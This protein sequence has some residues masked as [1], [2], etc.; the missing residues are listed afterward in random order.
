MNDPD[1]ELGETTAASQ[2]R[3]FSDLTF[4]DLF[5]V[6]EIQQIQDAFAESTGVAS[7]IT[8]VEGRP[9]TRPSN[10]C[11]LCEKIIRCT[12]KG[13]NN[14]MHSD[15]VL[16]RPNPNGPIFQPCL[17]GG[18]WDAGASVCVGDQHIANWLIGQVLTEDANTEQMMDYAREIGA[19][20][21]QFRCAL[22]EVTRMPLEQFKRVANSLF[23]FARQLSRLA[24]QNVQ[25]AR[26]MAARQR[27]Q[28]ELAR[29]RD[30]L[31]ELVKQ[32][33]AT[34]EERTGQLAHANADLERAKEAAEASSRAKSTF[35]ANMSH[36]IRT[37]MNAIIGMTELLLDTRV[38]AEQRDYLKVVAE[39]G[40]ALLSVIDDILD[41]SRIEAGKLVLCPEVFELRE[42]LGDTMKSLAVRAHGKGLEVACHIGPEVPPA[43]VGDRARLRQ[44]VINLVGNAIKFTDSGEVVLEVRQESQSNGQVQLHFTVT[45]TGIGIAK[46]KC[47]AIF[48]SFEQVDSSMRRRH[49]GAGLGL[50]IS[51]RLVNLMGGRIWVE[52]DLGRGSRFHFITRFTLATDDAAALRP[53]E[54]EVL[55]G[56]RVLVVDD[57]ATNCRILAEMLSNRGMEPTVITKADEAL[58]CMREAH[59]A[60]A[61]YRLVLTDAHMPEIDGFSLA[62]QIRGDKVTGST[63]IMMLTSGGQPSDVSRCEQL[64]ISS[65]LLKPIKQS[66][67]VDAIMMALGIAVVEADQ[68]DAES[69]SRH[70]SLRILLA[71]DSLVNQKLAVLVLEKEGHEVVVANNGVEAVAAVRSDS[72]DLVLMDVQM[73]E[74][75]G[76]EATAE[77]RAFE[78]TTG[79]HTPIIAMTAHAMK[80]DRELCLETGM[81]GYVAKPIRRKELFAKIE[82]VLDRGAPATPEAPGAGDQE[83]AFDWHRAL[84][85]IGDDPEQ[86]PEMVRIL[87]EAV[88]EEC[89]RLVEQIREAVDRGD[90]TAIRQTAHKLKGSVSYFGESPVF[91]QSLR[92]EAMGEEGELARARET[93]LVLQS[94]TVQMTSILRATPAL[95]G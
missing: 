90:A 28:E 50:A 46:E 25:Q 35:L 36:E 83:P 72:F 18:L 8:D 11:R 70:G 24:L 20:E 78:Q 41:F 85:E 77:I 54:P 65:Y 1:S 22:G 95:G 81:D 94:D 73:P 60:G 71:E 13:L 15:A 75:D 62:D 56:M 26:E 89:P 31:E 52:S 55:Q 58:D 32:R 59:H 30:N 76:L 34:L 4:A 57:N 82:E 45:D 86:G 42:S 33:T 21:D 53:A 23:L 17:S 6:D 3:R 66:E 5:D 79:G 69:A 74:M 10:F 61:P 84:A 80:G 40:E 7:I 43:V 48:G 29:H 87:V 38:T 47:D 68:P 2:A 44:V 27:V 16:G 67:L 92:L 63:V 39:S 37:P 91:Q 14:C 93:L 64:G 12:D 9:I 51:S 19:D 88:L 49:G